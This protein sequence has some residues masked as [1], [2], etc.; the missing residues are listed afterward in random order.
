M[1]GWWSMCRNTVVFETGAAVGV[2]D[3][4]H[5]QGR[6]A[7]NRRKSAGLT[8]VG[9][10]SYKVHPLASLS[11]LEWH[12]LTSTAWAH[13]SQSDEQRRDSTLLTASIHHRTA[14]FNGTGRGRQVLVAAW[15]RERRGFWRQCPV[16]MAGCGSMHTH[17]RHCRGRHRFQ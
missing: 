4:L 6:G 8:K 2:G 10:W 7:K 11:H 16:A 9:A 13:S 1:P 5:Q 12:P 3:T 17:R 15:T 14:I